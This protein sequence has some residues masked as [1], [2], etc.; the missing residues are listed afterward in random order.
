MW[1]RGR[2]R[3]RR[4]NTTHDPRARVRACVRACAGARQKEHADAITLAQSERLREEMRRRI[5]ELEARR[6]RRSSSSSSSGSG[7]NRRP[8]RPRLAEAAVGKEIGGRTEG[9]DNGR[10][11][12]R[13]R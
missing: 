6:R 2:G 9:G 5:N 1:W 11:K 10:D 4:A 7:S 12:E 13:E 3:W 8:R